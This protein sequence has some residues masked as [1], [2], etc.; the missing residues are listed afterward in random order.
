[1]AGIELT[2]KHSMRQNPVNN[3]DKSLYANWSSIATNT[4]EKGNHQ[5]KRNVRL[6]EDEMF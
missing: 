4:N 5:D 3:N 6:Y 1:M 2:V